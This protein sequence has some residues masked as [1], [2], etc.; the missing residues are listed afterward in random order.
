MPAKVSRRLVIDA[1]VARA[2]GGEDARELFAVASG[3]VGE[4]RSIVWVNPEKTEEK[5]IAW[6]E[7]GAEAEKERLLGFEEEKHS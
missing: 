7:N 5:S 2:A 6:L 1:T 4:L 3:R